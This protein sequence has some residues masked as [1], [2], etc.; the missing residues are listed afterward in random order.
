MKLFEIYGSQDYKTLYYKNRAFGKKYVG[1][2]IGTSFH[3]EWEKCEVEVVFKGK[4][5]N[6]ETD[7]IDFGGLMEIVLNQKAKSKLEDLILPYCEL[8]PL[9]LEGEEFYLLNP[10]VVLDC[11]DL[12]K[13]QTKKTPPLYNEKITKYVF[14][15]ERDYPSVFRIKNE[16]RKYIVTE[17]F[18]KRL[19]ENA[20]VGYGLVKLWDSENA[21]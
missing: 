2:F 3:D 18:V 15:R 11:L 4:W 16:P 19:E 7:I 14:K 21:E 5:G 9:E 10:I 1:K 17:E 20:L 13:C 6:K 8:L 12:K